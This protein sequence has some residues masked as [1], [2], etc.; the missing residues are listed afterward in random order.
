MRVFLINPR[1]SSQFETF[2]PVKDSLPPLGLAFLGSSLEKAG[3]EVNIFDNYLFRVPI[4]EVIKRAGKFNADII[5]IT[6]MSMSFS[7]VKK[8]VSAIKDVFQVPVVMGGPHAT[9]RPAQTLLKTRADIVVRGE[10]ELSFNRLI[11]CLEKKRNLTQLRGISYRENGKI[12]HNPPQAL[13][14]NLDKLPPPAWHLLPMKDYPRKSEL[15]N[16]YPLDSHNTSRGCPFFCAFCSVRNLWGRTFRSFS[17]ERMV[18]D[19]KFL[20]E[21]FGTKGIYFREDN[22]TVSKKRV[23]K[24]CNLIKKDKLDFRWICESRVDLVDFEI[25]TTMKKAGCDYIWFGVESASPRIL[26]YINKGITVEKTIKAFQLCKRVG[27][28]TGASLMV[29]IPQETI[30]EVQKTLKLRV[31]L[32]QDFGSD[33][34][35]NI[36]SGIPGSLLYDSIVQKGWFKNM[37][38]SGICEVVTPEFDKEMLIRIV[39]SSNAEMALKPRFILRKLRNVKSLKELTSLQRAFL[40][41]L[42]FRR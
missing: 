21:K 13:I 26:Q 33:V 7:E 14:K 11:D 35:V 5:G 29:G 4:V 38:E 31:K 37:D 17:P 12:I 19:V 27:I 25:L 10:G 30:N 2:L 42:K 40:H 34:W 9:L 23:F 18:E 16:L 28:R 8:T 32:F 41:L 1:P 15:L 36:F 22:F 3:H 39:N 6:C 20:M 24:F